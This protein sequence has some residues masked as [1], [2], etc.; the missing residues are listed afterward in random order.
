MNRFRELGLQLLALLDQCRGRP[1]QHATNGAERAQHNQRRRDTT[2]NAESLEDV[3]PASH[4]QPE[5][6]GQED[7]KQQRADGPGQL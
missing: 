4:R 1:R 7:E 6:G 5:E 2:A 3:D